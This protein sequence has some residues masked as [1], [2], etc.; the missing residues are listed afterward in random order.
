M[1]ADAVGIAPAALPEGE[2]GGAA[3]YR[4]WVAAGMHATMG[5]MAR[6][7]E[8]RDGAASWFPPAKSVVVLAFSYDPGPDGASDGGRISR[9]ARSDDY[10][11]VLRSRLDALLAAIRAA[12]PDVQGKAFV[13][14]SAVLERLYG[15]YAGLGWIGKNTMLLSNRIGSYFFLAG[16][17]IDKE[18]PY[19]EPLPD[20]C[21]TCTRCLDACPTDA[22][23]APRV[24]DASRC[25]AYLTIEHRGPVPKALRPG[26]GDWAFGCDVCQDVCP[27]NR[28]SVRTSMFPPKIGARVPLER[29]ASMSEAEFDA[30]FE[31][32]PIERTGLQGL[33]RNALLAMGNS[34]EARW[35]GA[36]EAA[37][38]DPDPTVAEQARWSLGRIGE[39]A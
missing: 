13:D 5:Y 23:P 31:T 8:R 26:V 39:T 30:S 10:H 36:L 35:K 7:P 21:G 15:R 32:T 16:L 22:F 38:L 6:R 14:T 4:D 9:Y 28:F 24:L 25:I 3:A 12:A 33:R 1:G 19:D 18:L 37:A 17:A 29:L 34:G 27:W 2:P 20:H 11:E